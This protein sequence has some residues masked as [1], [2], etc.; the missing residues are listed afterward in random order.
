M[1]SARGSQ[2]E[3]DR[4]AGKLAS[5]TLTPR[6]SSS[7]KLAGLDVSNARQQLAPGHK[8]GVDTVPLIPASG[9][10]GEI[11]P[12]SSESVI[13]M[14]TPRTPDN[15]SDVRKRHKRRT[16]PGEIT[17]HWGMKT[18]SFPQAGDGYGVKSK[19]GESAAENFRAGQKLGIAEYIQS[20]GESIYYSVRQEPLGRSALRGH[21]LPEETEKQAFRGFGK[22]MVPDTHDAKESIFPRFVDP[23]NQEDK[24][25]YKK[26]HGAFDPGEPI[27]REY[28]W[29]QKITGN[30]HFRFG[31][32]DTTKPGNLNSG[33]GAKNA[34]TMDL[35]EDRTYPRTRVVDLSAEHFRQ[36]ANDGLG[37]SR[38]MLQGRPPVVPGH[39]FGI[40]SGSDNT[41]AG[42]LMRGFYPPSQQKPDT[43]LG[44]CCIKGRRNFQTK[45]PFG[46]PSVRHDLEPPPV[47]K[48][49]VA[50][51]TNYGDDHSAF[52]LIYPEKFGFRGVHDAAFFLPRPPDEMKSLLDEC[53]YKLEEQDFQ[54]LWAEAA[55]MSGEQPGVNVDGLRVNLEVMLNVLGHWMSVTGVKLDRTGMRADNTQLPVQ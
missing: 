22:A 8:K 18:T 37:K 33:D 30:Q 44:K 26:T 13:I 46:V 14:E 29:P 21:V 43:D 34:L 54:M 39:A 52:S 20:T 15:I 49:S 9:K 42:E 6:E 53:G 3:S 27:S 35:E 4:V 51:A 2:A 36:V 45:R 1:L 28:S 7:L 17:T 32:T 47:H 5:G 55:Q 19:K 41:H 31:A 25:R 10:P 23:E 40:K 12:W 11:A 16:D 38:N 48:R 50:S 24:A